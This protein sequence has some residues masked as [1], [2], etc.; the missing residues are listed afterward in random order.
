MECCKETF[1]ISRPVWKGAGLQTFHSRQNDLLL[2]CLN[3][4][5]SQGRYHSHELS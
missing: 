4:H 5:C 3:E 2:F 1:T